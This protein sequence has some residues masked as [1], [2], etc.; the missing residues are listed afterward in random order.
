M[1]QPNLINKPEVTNTTKEN[2]LTEILHEIQTTPK[3]YWPNLLQ[4]MRV[5][6]ESVT[7]K[8]DLL[9]HNQQ[10]IDAKQQQLLNQQ[11]Q[12]LKQLTKE[13]LEEGEQQEQT[14]TWEYLRQ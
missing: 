8:T 11:H 3:E 9:N 12:A 5:F 6:R 4:I 10:E 13:W 7:F 1:S 2:Y 14:E